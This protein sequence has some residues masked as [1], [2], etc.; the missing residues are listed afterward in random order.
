MVA[1]LWHKLIDV[2]VSLVSLFLM[3]KFFLMT[4]GVRLSIAGILA[5]FK[6]KEK[7]R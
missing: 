6:K 1:N 5:P 7:K 4:A 3:V 2:F